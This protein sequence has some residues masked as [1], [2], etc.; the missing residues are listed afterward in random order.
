[1]RLSLIPLA[2]LAVANAIPTTQ[3]P[4]E[5][6]AAAADDSARQSFTLPVRTNPDYVP[7]GPAEFAAAR[8]KW[9]M[10]VPEGLD[11][12]LLTRRQYSCT[13]C[14]LSSLLANPSRQTETERETQD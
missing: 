7:D 10:P 12:H 6:A 3:Q 2:W 9:N 14:L 4:E 8:R 13:F 5:P 11:T 1:M